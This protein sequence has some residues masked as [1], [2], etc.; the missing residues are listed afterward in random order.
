[1]KNLNIKKEERN[2][3]IALSKESIRKSSDRICT[4]KLALKGLMG[5]LPEYIVDKLI[6]IGA[7]ISS[8]IGAIKFYETKIKA[9]EDENE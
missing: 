7:E 8:E 2:E 6:E 9:L 5:D 4:L 1:M 3:Y